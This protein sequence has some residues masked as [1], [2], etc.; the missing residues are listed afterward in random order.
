V[1]GTATITGNLN[2]SGAPAG[3]DVTFGGNGCGGPTVNKNLYADNNAGPVSVQGTTVGG[4]E[5]V[6]NNTGP[7]PVVAGNSVTSYLYCSPATGAGNTAKKI[8]GTC[9]V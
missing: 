3:S 6:Q 5:S 9:T 2:E 7:T 1:I 4:N 8:Y